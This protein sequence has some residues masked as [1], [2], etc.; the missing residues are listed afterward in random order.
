MSEVQTRAALAVRDEESHE[1]VGRASTTVQADDLLRLALERD[2]GI[3]VVERIVALRERDQQMRAEAEMAEAL[4]DFQAACPSIRRTADG[5]HGKFADY[6]TIVGVVRPIMADHGLS[7]THDSVDDGKNVTTT[8]T[9]RHVSGATRTA[10]FT[11]PYDS[12]GSKNPLQARASARSYGK[13]YTLSDVLGIATEDDDDGDGAG[14]SAEFVS[15]EQAAELKALGEDV[16]ID[17]PGFFEWLNVE[18][19]ETI[20]ARRFKEATNAI[21]R[22]RRQKAKAAS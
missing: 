16:G 21:E 20:P 9:L 14:G 2:G 12:S 1:L 19:W 8:C 15:E 3:D 13:R 11:G 18:S 22:K 6:G 5:H 4:A 10:T 17:V 7:F